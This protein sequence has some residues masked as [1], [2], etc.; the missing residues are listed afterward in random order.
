MTLT[1]L[2]L[3]TRSSA[4]AMWQSSWVARQLTEHGYDVELVQ[5]T[6]QGD[7]RSEP[8]GQIGGQG[9]FTKEIQ[10][11]LLDQEVD[12]AVHS[13]KDLP[14]V[15]VPGLAL[16]AVPPRESPGDA[17]LSNRFDSI[18]SI[19]E[20]A[21][22]GTGSNRRQAQLLHYRADVVV[23]GIRGNVDTRI[24][25]LDDGQFDAIVLAESGLRRLGLQER[26]TQLIPREIMLPAVGQGALG[27]ECRSDDDVTR[28]AVS[29]L[30]DSQTHLSVLAERA[31]LFTLQAG[32][33]APVGTYARFENGSLILEGAVLS[34]DGKQR[35][36]EVA[37]VPLQGVSNEDAVSLGEQ[38]AHEL[39]GQGAKQLIDAAHQ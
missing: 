6:T 13:L 32:C 19:P 20:G 37:S 12:L 23:R 11:A 16:G 39:L 17:L 9:L 38:V 36:A 24:G 1:H 35:L 21:V 2:R 29:L 25:K 15:P 7:V 31:L 4:L 5:I 14:T 28:Q 26:I 10:R 22:I 8:I 18:E 30:N 33:L 27:I 34:V 3:G